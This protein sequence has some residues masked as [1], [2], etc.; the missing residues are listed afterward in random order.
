MKAKNLSFS[1]FCELQ[2]L[3]FVVHEIWISSTGP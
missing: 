1:L 2:L 3:E